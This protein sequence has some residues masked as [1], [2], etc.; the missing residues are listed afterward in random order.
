MSKNR[1]GP[2][3]NVKDQNARVAQAPGTV[4]SIPATGV[5][6]TVV[7]DALLY[8]PSSLISLPTDRLTPQRTGRYLVGA[9]GGLVSAEPTGFAA[10]QLTRDGAPP[11][12]LVSNGPMGGFDAPFSLVAELEAGDVIQ[13]A[14][15]QSGGAPIDFAA[16]SLYLEQLGT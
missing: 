3:G 13:L 1:T 6:T 11:V 15:A 12:A 16:A 5:L 9:S 10:I 8:G 2:S 14:A 7:F 4:T